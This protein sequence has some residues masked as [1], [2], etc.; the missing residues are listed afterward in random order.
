MSRQPV[1]RKSENPSTSRVILIKQTRLAEP[2]TFI[3]AFGAKARLTDSKD[4]YC[5]WQVESSRRFADGL[6][7]DI[8]A[9][10]HQVA[11]N[12]GSRIIWKETQGAIRWSGIRRDRVA[13]FSGVC[14]VTCYPSCSHGINLDRNTSSRGRQRQSRASSQGS[15]FMLS[16]HFAVRSRP[17]L[18]QSMHP[19]P[20]FCSCSLLPL[21]LQQTNP[22]KEES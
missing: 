12:Y 18:L 22:H 5:V 19:P 10:K 2:T 9:K 7:S 15:T 21:P 11:K 13:R 3:F 14:E 4:L 8:V 1:L 17:L 16:R 20:P 6:R